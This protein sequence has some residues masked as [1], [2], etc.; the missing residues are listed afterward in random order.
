MLSLLFVESPLAQSA[1][2]LRVRVRH[3]STAPPTVV[4]YEAPPVIDNTSIDDMARWI[5]NKGLPLTPTDLLPPTVTD[6][7]L[8]LPVELSCSAVGASSFA[9]FI[10]PTNPP[11]LIASGTPTCKMVATQGN[12]G[13]TIY[14][15]VVAKNAVGES[16]GPLR[17]FVVGGST[18]TVVGADLVTGGQWMNTYGADGYSLAGDGATLPSYA[19]V[20]LTAPVYTWDEDTPDTRGLA[21]PGGGYLASTWYS[22]TSFDIGFNLTDGRLHQVSL[23]L[24]DWDYGGRSERIE[25]IDA[26]SGQVVDTRTARD[27]STGAYLSYILSGRVTL[28]LTKLSGPNAVVSGIFFEPP[29]GDLALSWEPNPEREQIVR[30]EVGFGPTRGTYPETINVGLVTYW[31]ITGIPADGRPYWIAVRALNATGASPWSA[32]IAVVLLPPKG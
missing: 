5:A 8:L 26:T 6:E 4:V 25:A 32:P 3:Q 17:S 13:Q 21:K 20:M 9:W 16:S 19:Q 12:P 23:Y 18:I 14:W 2:S 1:P 24:L 7:A 31:D 22:G 27:F 10:G 11:P 29:V 30:Y 28:R 15:R